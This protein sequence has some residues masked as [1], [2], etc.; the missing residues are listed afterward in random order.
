MAVSTPAQSKSPSSADAGVAPGGSRGLWLLAALVVLGALVRFPTLSSQSFWYDEAVT[1]GIVAHSL[2]HVLSTVPKTESTPPLY[3]VLVWLWSRVFGASEAGLRSFSA[4][5]GTLSIP[6]MWLLGKRL[7]SERVG[8]VAALLTA[9]SPIL[10]W[11]SQEARSYSLLV[12]LSALSLL[13]LVWALE[14]PSPRRLLAW[15]ASGAVALCVHYF[16]IF[17]VAAEALWLIIALR[18][19]GV[20]KRSWIALALAPIVAVG[21]ALLPLSI[22]QN[23]GRAG[24]IADRAGSLAFRTAQLFKQDIAAF[25]EP[26]KLFTSVAAAVLVLIGLL[27]LARTTRRERA[28]LIVPLL[29][30]AGALLLAL[31]AAGLGTDYVNTRNLLPSWPAL[32]LVVAGGFGAARA[33]RAGWLA[34]GA[35]VAVSVACV[36]AVDT[37]ATFQRADWRGAAQGMGS[38]STPRAIMADHN[39]R[40]ALGPYMGRLSAFRDGTPVREVDVFALVYRKSGASVSSPPPRPATAPT[41]PGFSVFARRETAGYTVLRYRAR[42]PVPE[43]VAALTRLE[44]VS[45]GAYAALLQSPG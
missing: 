39:A 27:L 21:A 19:A 8:L 4:L 36:V 16:A 13:A 31:L 17:L 12:L 11:Y 32:A 18:R 3:Y 1:H 28:G 26:S 5:C 2:G 7:V 43:T 14:S 25:D 37:T 22:H 29:V 38:A 23:D 15:G 42:T 41:L 45:G 44:L 9:V 24:F 35:L 40:I 6:V 10:F 33:G 34:L 30:G 20:A